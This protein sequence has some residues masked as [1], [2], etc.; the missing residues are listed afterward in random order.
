MGIIS[1]VR[2]GIKRFVLRDEFNDIKAVGIVNNTSAAP[3]PGVRTVVDTENKLSI[4]NRKLTFT[5]GKT[6]ASYTDPRLNYASVGRKAGRALCFTITL[7][8]TD[9]HVRFGWA[10]SAIDFNGDAMIHFSNGAT[11]NI[12]SSATINAQNLSSYTATTY[13]VSVVLRTTGAMWFIRG[14]VFT[15]WTL[16]WINETGNTANLIPSIFNHSSAIT[17]SDW[18]I[19]DL[20]NP[21]NTMYGLATSRLATSSAG[22]EITS[23][24]DTFIEFTWIAITGETLEISFRYTDADNRWIIR[25]NQTDSTIKVIEKFFGVE[26]ERSSVAQTW[27]N[28]TSYR[29]VIMVY[30]ELVKTYIAGLLKNNY[31]FAFNNKYISNSKVKVSHTVT[32]LIAWPILFRGQSYPMTPIP[33]VTRTYRLNKHINP[34]LGKRVGKW[35]AWGTREICILKDESGNIAYDGDNKMTSFYWGRETQSGIPSIGIAKSSDGV[36]WD[37]RL[38]APLIPANSGVNG[39]WYENGILTASAIKRTIDG[40]IMLLAT[41]WG[42]MGSSFGVFTSADGGTTWVEVGSLI[43]STSFKNEDG[44][45]LMGFGVPSIIKKSSGGYI[46]LFEGR[47]GVVANKWRIF[48]MESSDFI[49]TWTPLNEGY[50]VFVPDPN[51]WDSDGVANPHLIEKTDGHFLMIYNGIPL[52]TYGWRIGIAETTDFINWTRYQHN[53]ILHNGGGTWENVQTETC[54][55]IKD[56]F[57]AKLYYQGYSATGAHEIGLAEFY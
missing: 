5:G 29:I 36:T 48:A 43:A 46:C 21:Y 38:D 19:I 49:G 14:G 30:D 25:C 37:D 39:S 31:T 16:L 35:D 1:W 10:T 28:G 47:L 56:N 33:E 42:D 17:I 11:I 41:G 4:I 51:S 6:V 52:T 34:L 45:I 44:S 12:S 27:T 18:K 8:A 26:T 20:P 22:D 7:P 13:K 15:N 23:L 55:I 2:G 3:G 50:P 53:P 24:A 32:N 54:D 40:L 9:K 57:P